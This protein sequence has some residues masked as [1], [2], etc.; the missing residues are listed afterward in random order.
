MEHCPNESK[1]DTQCYT[2]MWSG[3]VGGTYYLVITGS[4][5][6][7]NSTSNF[8]INATEHGKPPDVQLNTLQVMRYMGSYDQLGRSGF[9]IMIHKW[10]SESWLT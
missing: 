8:T 9:G 6:Y 10:C 5:I 7:G 3:K 2:C 4:S 1:I